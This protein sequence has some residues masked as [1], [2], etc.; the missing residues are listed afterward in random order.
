MSKGR[1]HEDTPDGNTLRPRQ[2][3]LLGP[4]V[5][6]LSIHL[7]FYLSAW[8]TDHM[9]PMFPIGSIQT[10]KTLDY[11]QVPNGAKSYFEG[12]SIVGQRREFPVLPNVY[13]PAFTVVVG[14]VLKTWDEQ[15]GFFIYSLFKLAASLALAAIIFRLH[16]DAPHRVL[17]AF[18]YFCF[19]SEAVEIGSGQYHFL[20]NAA[21]F[22]MLMIPLEP[23]SQRGES[24][25]TLGYFGSLLIKPIGALWLLPLWMNRRYR[26]AIFGFGLFAIVTALFWLDKEAGGDYYV[27]NL[28]KRTSDLKLVEEPTYTFNWL[29]SYFHV[30][31]DGLRMAKYAAGL[32]LFVYT[33]LVGP[34]LFIGMFL[35]T[36][37][38]LLF[39]I[40]VFEYH[41]TSLVPFYVLGV[42]T[43]PEFQRPLVRAAI[44]WSCLPSP[45]LL[46]QSSGMFASPQSAELNPHGLLIVVGWKVVPLLIVVGSVIRDSIREKR[47]S[48][49]GASNTSSSKSAIKK[50]TSAQS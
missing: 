49:A 25:R 9:R 5:L 13:H 35:W 17:A 46:L 10:R 43:R 3:L 40:W 48:A 42:M 28:A 36:A 12:G 2:T 50:A 1:P 8:Q 38:Y 22:L 18:V 14:G 24:L 41:Y 34:T 7:T 32:G 47:T 33:A 21:V 16:P 20:L 19:F 15:T 11:Y 45:Y 44:V 4:L 23:A 39:Y 29:L 26:A 37:Y 6:F 31:P 30:S 27:A